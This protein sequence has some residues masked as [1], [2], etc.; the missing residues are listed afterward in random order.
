MC[1]VALVLPDDV[2]RVFDL[3]YGYNAEVGRE[4]EYIQTIGHN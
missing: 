1:A 3:F 2:N 4:Y